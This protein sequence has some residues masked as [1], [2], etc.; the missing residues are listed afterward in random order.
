[1]SPLTLQRPRRRLFVV[2]TFPQPRP[3]GLPASSMREQLARIA[4]R[5]T[6]GMIMTPLEE[7]VTVEASSA[8]AAARQ[9][10][11][12]SYDQMPVIEGAAVVGVLFGE[13]MKDLDHHSAVGS[14][15]R[16]IQAMPAVRSDH[17]FADAFPV[18]IQHPCV[19]V[20]HP[21]DDVFAGILHFSDV[22]KHEVRANL[23]L[24]LSAL[25]MNLARLLRRHCPDF[26]TWLRCL[27]EP[28][29]VLVLGRYELERRRHVELHPVEGTELSDL[30]KIF[31]SIPG[32]L[33]PLGLTK[34]QFEK[35]TGRLITLR[36]AAMH[37]VRSLVRA[38]SDV[39]RLTTRLFDV[40]DL[41]ERTSRALDVPPP[42]LA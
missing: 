37:P 23:Y 17:T 31:R 42:V 18:L 2:S 29:Q 36:N 1:V 16:P 11:G 10:M 33:E 15:M 40:I 12:T 14:V 9:R 20:R 26:D 41:I 5:M 30:I 32:L 4:Q 22:N 3:A 25:E 8:I 27:D 28:R 7:L 39:K 13:D 6:V 35:K 34:S 24:W 38:H 19:A 21:P